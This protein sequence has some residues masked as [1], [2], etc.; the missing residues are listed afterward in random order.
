LPN[1]EKTE[2]LGS[3]NPAPLGI[4]RND[5]IDPSFLLDE[6]TSPRGSFELGDT[7]HIHGPTTSR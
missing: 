6:P 7:G 2:R 1:L 3:L 5:E 4:A